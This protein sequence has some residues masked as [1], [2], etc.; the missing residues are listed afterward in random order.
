MCLSCGNSIPTEAVFCPNCGQ[1]QEPITQEVEKSVQNTEESIG[2]DIEETTVQDAI[3][4]ADFNLASEEQNQQSDP[5]TEQSSLEM[6]TILQQQEPVSPAPAE[7]AKQPPVS[8]TPEEEQQQPYGQATAHAQSQQPQYQQPYY[9]QKAQQSAAPQNSKKKFPWVFTVVWIGMLIFVG[10]WIYLW[11]TYPESQKPVLGVDTFRILAPVVS[12]VLLLYTL[13]LKLIVKKLKV[14]PT[15]LLILSLLFC[16]FM[17]LSYELI[18]GDM[19]H[20]LISP[21]TESFNEFIGIE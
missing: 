5:G 6:D 13:N 20:D 1:K 4:E 2:S 3:F 17:F 12:A 8:P 18:E 9:S 21:V 16:L 19:L 14:I 11:S 7:E 10:V 15:I